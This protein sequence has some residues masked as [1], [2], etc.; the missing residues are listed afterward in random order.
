MDTS[1]LPAPVPAQEVLQTERYGNAA[2]FS[3]TIPG[4]NAGQTYPVWLYF[5]EGY[6]TAAG[7]REFGV[8]INGAQVLP[9]LPAACRHL[10][11][12]RVESYLRP[13]QTVAGPREA[14][15]SGPFRNS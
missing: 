15:I 11:H 8:T 10:R 1:L 13:I 14:D 7:Q 3:Y 12:H 4:L 2:A 5:D 9:A 6:F